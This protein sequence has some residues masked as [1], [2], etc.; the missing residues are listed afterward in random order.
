M[1]RER[2]QIDGR[3]GGQQTSMESELFHEE[4]QKER[5]KG[6]RED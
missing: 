6:K 3:I 5:R 1:L 4:T 2:S